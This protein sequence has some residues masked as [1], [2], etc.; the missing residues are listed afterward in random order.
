MNRDECQHGQLSRQCEICELQNDRARLVHALDRYMAACV[1]Y[2]D[3]QWDLVNIRKYA[4]AKAHAEA[5][6]GEF[7]EASES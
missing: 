6:L 5:V 7:R 1:C 3:N 2:Q 4:E